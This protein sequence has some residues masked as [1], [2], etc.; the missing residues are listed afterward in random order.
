MS[1]EKMQPVR[2]PTPPRSSAVVEVFARASEDAAPKEGDPIERRDDQFELEI[3]TWIEKFAALAELKTVALS[4]E[5]LLLVSEL[6]ASGS[7]TEEAIARV[8]AKRRKARSDADAV[9]TLAKE[10]TAES[11]GTLMYALRHRAG[12]E[13]D[14]VARAL[15]ISVERLLAIEADRIPW[16]QMRPQV[17]PIFAQLVG[18]TISDMVSLFRITARRLFVWEIRQRTSLSLARFDKTQEI[19]DADRTKVRLAFER[20]KEHN[21]AAG[22]FLL[23]VEQSSASHNA[24]PSPPSGR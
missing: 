19:S 16:Y 4:D 22:A 11:P 21:R 1:P 13:N 6:V 12:L 15:E 24:A 8:E 5:A 2:P 18:E 20:L 10:C 7:V 23:Q 14:V 3:D 9:S 17:V